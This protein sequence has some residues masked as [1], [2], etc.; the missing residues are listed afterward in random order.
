MG[1]DG[2]GGGDQPLAVDRSRSRCRRPRPRRRGCRGCL[3]GR[4]RRCA[5]PRM[6]IDALRM[7]RTGSTSRHVGDHEVA[8]PVTAARRQVHARRGRSCRSRCSNSSPRAGRRRPR[9]RRRARCRRDAPGRRSVGAVD[10]R[11]TSSAVRSARPTGPSV[12]R[13]LVR[14]RP[15][16]RG[17]RTPGPAPGRLPGAVGVERA[18][19]EA[20]EPDRDPGAADRD[21]RHG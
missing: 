15:A 11:R 7:P 6:P 20:R 19:D 1:V 2:A 12:A 9:P 5:R 8:R 13:P 18:V 3:P 10:A 17:S 14:G 16:L 4:R 21:E